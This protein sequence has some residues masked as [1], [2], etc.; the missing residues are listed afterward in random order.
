VLA[1]RLGIESID[2]DGRSVVL[3]FRPQA[4]VDPARLVALVRQRPDLALVPPAALRMDLSQAPGSGLQT[5]ERGPKTTSR[6]PKSTGA[7]SWWTARARAGEVRPGFTKAE[8]LRPAKADPRAAGG[9]FDR[10]GTLLSELA[11]RM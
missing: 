7:Q 2:R 5:A 3:K 4:K 1:D 10:V 6:S 9:V 11:A 8:I